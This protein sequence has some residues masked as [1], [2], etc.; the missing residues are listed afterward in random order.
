MKGRF[1]MRMSA[2]FAA[3]A[4]TFV[5]GGMGITARA[6]VA[7][8]GPRGGE[9]VGVG[10]TNA[11]DEEELIRKLTGESPDEMGAAE[12]MMAEVTRRM[13]GIGRAGSRRGTRGT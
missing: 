13:G 8:T 5:A 6:D 3:M 9:M 2:R 10:A 11:V 7:A 4:M 1:T 12:R